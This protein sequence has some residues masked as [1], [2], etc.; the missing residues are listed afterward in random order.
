MI[1]NHCNIFSIQVQSSTPFKI[2]MKYRRVTA[3]ELHS[4]PISIYG[5]TYGSPPK[6]FTDQIKCKDLYV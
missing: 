6:I 5:S 4:V 3:V 1:I 2:S